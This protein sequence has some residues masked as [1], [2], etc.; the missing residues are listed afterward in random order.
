VPA[1]L[2]R[3][4]RRRI[5]S[6]QS[7]QKITRAME[8]IAASRITRAQHAILAAAPYAERLRDVASELAADPE[9]SGHWVFGGAPR[10]S[11][12]PA[13]D[14]RL[15]ERSG[16]GAQAG[17]TAVV[18]IGADR[19]LAGAFN[20]FV[21]RAADELVSDL[22]ARG[23]APVLIAVGRKAIA[24]F[25]SRGR[26]LVAQFEGFADRPRFDDAR[27]VVEAVSEQLKGGA[28]SVYVVSTRFISSGSQRVESRRL[29]PLER[30]ERRGATVFEFEPGPAEIM[31]RLLPQWLEAEVFVALLEAAAAFHVSQQ[32]AMA[33]ATDNADE[34]IKTLTRH[35]NRARQD[36]ITTEIIEIVGG[37]EALR[38]DTGGDK[39]TRPD[40]YVFPE[41]S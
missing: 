16:G 9:A 15:G 7:T 40:V 35:M 13:G 18:V 36:S 2:E 12:S 8:L 26:D 31:D 4:L 33:A 5:R 32:R 3:Q 10:P 29:V 6:V 22:A 38:Q 20:L 30:E 28:N 17:G 39:L 25:R 1:G 19:G 27:R 37:A 34:L 23:Q 41:A 21:Q 24:H 14:G 11:G